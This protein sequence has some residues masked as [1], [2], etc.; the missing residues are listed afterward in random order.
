M[1]LLDSH[2]VNQI[3]AGE[4]V[5]RPAA[6][7]KELVENALDA[8]ATRVDVEV[9]DAGRRLIRVSDDGHG[10]SDEDARAALLRHATSKIGS[11]DDLLRVASFG[12]RG[13]ALPSIASVSRLT[14]ST[15]TADGVRRVL[16]VEEGLTTRD[17][18][19]GGPQGTTVTVED[20]FLCVPARLKFLKSDTTEV[21]AVADVVGRAATARPDVAFRLSHGGTVVLQTPGSGSLLDAV[22]AVWGRDPARG[23][24][25]VDT[26][27]GHA[28]VW[29]LVSPPHFTKPTRSHQWLFVNGRPVRSRLGTAAL[30]QA[31]RSLTPEKRYP[32][33]VVMVEVDPAQI[34]VNVSPSKSEV[35]FHQEGAV[36]DAVRRAVK[37]AVLASGAV[38]SLEGLAAANAAL[39]P[40]AAAPP[41]A[42]FHV[43]FGEGLSSTPAF[44][45]PPV[46]TPDSFVDGL[47]VLG[48]IDDT[49]I[50][51]ENRTS[52]LVV[53]QHVAHERVLYE[54]IRDTRGAGAVETQRLIEPE[55]LVVGRRTLE[56]VTPRLGELREVGFDVE[57]FGTETLL[58][59]SVPALGRF[60]PPLAA[61]K[62][63][64]DEMV[65][66]PPGALTP[67]RDDVY[68]LASCKLAV[69]AGDPL[70]HAEM[71]RLLHDLARTE[72]PYLC[73]H[74][75]PI[76]VVYPKDALARKFKR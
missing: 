29:G 30:D 48:Q 21:G 16:V 44:E 27:N 66:N 56:A 4:V 68:I 67:T 18:V 61:L 10:M 15:G 69:K 24:V 72:N 51:A 57:P 45:P 9:E 25:P 54:Q 60:R 19:E 37:D 11:A 64:L 63:I 28:R 33:A 70:G 34:D 75:R 17:A 59:R 43:A 50:V 26:F 5:D 12:F 8:G 53:D 22:A 52:L 32:L 47:R 71:T 1:R 39:S 58:V 42:L 3:A 49:F 2:T 38:P 65:E 31:F 13:E 62:D 46:A 74:G 41:A 76:T 6:A 55:T 14:L 7:V 36:F 20:L 73:P 40:E 23:L 35:K